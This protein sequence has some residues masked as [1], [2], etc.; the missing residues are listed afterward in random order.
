M[1][2]VAVIGGGIVG[3]STAYHLVRRGARVTVV[4]RSD[5]GQATLAG[6]GILPPLDHFGGSEAI[7]PLLRAARAHYPELVR[8]LW[9]EGQKDTGYAVVGSLQVALDETEAEGLRAL[10]RE[11]V[12]WRDAG[13]GHIGEVSEF[14]AS[15]A[16]RRCPLLGPRIVAALHCSGAARIDG[17]RL[18]AALRAAFCE[19]GGRW[20]RGHAELV[21]SAERVTHVALDNQKFAVDAAVLAGGAWTRSVAELCGALVPVRPQKGQLIHLE[22]DR[23]DTASLPIV[24]GLGWNYLVGFPEQRVVVGATREDAAGLDPRITAGAVQHVLDNAF[25]I[26]PSLAQSTLCEVRTGFRPVSADGLP[27]LGA[28]PSCENL[29]VATGHGGYGLELGPFSGALLADRIVGITP[30]VN[31]APFGLARFAR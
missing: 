5:A 22:V 27:I 14:D 23:V 1:L 13:F 31:L 29:Y 18:L 2:E 6:A 19:R 9:D 21:S 16:L 4:D 20:L 15:E 8:A 28:V 12:A 17:R 11:A 3:A 30:A 7:L 24:M 26:A 25:R 10:A